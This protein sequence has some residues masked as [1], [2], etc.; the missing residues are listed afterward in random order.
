M[1]P[2]GKLQRSITIERAHTVT[3]DAG[4]RST[5]WTSHATTRAELVEHA[6]SD[7]QRPS[8]AAIKERL[9]FRLRYLA[10][11]TPAD[12]LRFRGRQFGIVVV[13][14]LGRREE[15]EIVCE[16]IP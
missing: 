10:G 2:A 5:V 13:K 7:E 8:G 11:V 12:R 6:A 9:T 14:E 15:M 3:N 1:I 16:A 4:T